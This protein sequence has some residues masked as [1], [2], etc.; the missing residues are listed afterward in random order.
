MLSIFN[1]EIQNLNF[2]KTNTVFSGNTK[3]ITG[4][5]IISGSQIKL[6]STSRDGFLHLYDY[7]VI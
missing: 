4:L 6:L 1:I 3:A 7:K 2:V 5:S